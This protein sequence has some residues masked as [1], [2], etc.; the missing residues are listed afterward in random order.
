MKNNQDEAKFV[1]EGNPGQGNTFVHIGH[2]EHY[3]PNAT[4]VSTT[5]TN[6]NY[7]GSGE[8]GPREE[9]QTGR[10]MD[11]ISFRKL[12][13]EGH[14]NTPPLKQDILHYVHPIRQHVKPSHD[15]RFMSLW[16]EILEHE[17]FAVDLYDPGKQ[18]SNFNRNLVGQIL[19]YLNRKGFYE[20]T[21]SAAAMT[22]ALEHGNDQH[23]VRRELGREPDR[24]YREAVD[25]ILNKLENQ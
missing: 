11:T 4:S 22:R 14:I 19:C 3:N 24:Q 12:L 7:Y 10:K 1:I 9:K 6:H 13:E 21:Y 23:P 20:G 15:G 18:Q 5:I 16:Q 25:Q 2:V 17:A 8:Q